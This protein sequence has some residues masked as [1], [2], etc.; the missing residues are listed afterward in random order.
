MGQ[1]QENDRLIT[2][3][4]DPIEKV[5]ED[6]HTSYRGLEDQE[7]E[8]RQLKYGK[9]QLMD[10]RKDTVLLRLRRSF[11]NPFS[12]VLFILAVLSL[13]TNIIYSEKR[14]PDHMSVIIIFS[15]LLL[16]GII[17]FVQE[18]KS[19][20]IT[21]KLND[22]ISSHVW[23]K[24]SGIWQELDMEEIVT[25]DIIKLKAGDKIPADVRLIQSND[26]FVS[27]SVLTGESGIQEKTADVD[28]CIP[29]KISDCGNLAFQGCNV[30][31]GVME[32]VVLA[33]GNHTL[34]GNFSENTMERKKGF[35]RGANS[36]AWVLIRFMAIL[37]PIV[38][39]A[40][41]IT[42]DNWLMAFLFALSVAVGLTPE[43]LPMVVTACL[44]KGSNSMGAKE[45]IVKNMN[46]M[47]GF[48]S[49]DVLCVDKT[50]T[51]TGDELLLE[52]Y[53]DILGNEDQ[54]VLEMAYL[55]SYYSSGIQNHLDQSVIRSIEN[56]KRTE[57]YENLVKKHE[58]LDEIP[59]DYHRKTSSILVK[60]DGKN[61]LIVKGSIEAVLAKCS[62]A[63]Y[64]G[65]RIEK[66]SNAL[67]NVHAIVD[68]MLEDGMKILAIAKK[69]LKKDRIRPDDES[70]LTLAGYIAFFDAPKK[71][72]VTALSTLQN[73][74]VQ[75]KVLTGDDAA[76]AASICRRLNMDTSHVMTGRELENLSDNDSQTA[77][78]YT[79]VFAELSPKQ[80]KEIVSILQS[81]G[82]TVGFMGDGMNDLPAIMQTDVGISVDTASPAVKEAA[83]VILLKKDLNVLEEGILEGRRVF[84]NMSKYIKIT[85]SSNLGNIIA[86]VA[87]SIFLPFFPM[88]SIQLLLLNLLY[89]IICLVLPWDQV[90]RELYEKPLEWSGNRLSRFMLCFG[91]ISSI[92]DIITFGF[93]MFYLCPHL[94]GGNFFVLS[95]LEQ[96]KFIAIFQTGWFLESMWSQVLIL[97]LL[98]TKRFPMVQSRPSNIVIVITLAGI[99]LFT[100]IAMTP[101]GTLIGLTR[102]PAVYFAFLCVTVLCYLIVVTIVKKLYIRFFQNLI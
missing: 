52:Y 44:A 40:S 25:G 57:Y 10:G 82:H 2:A 73:L 85:A 80:K 12:V 74:N 37:V 9:N 6:L 69:D 1:M 39:I 5:Y 97:Y 70:D 96:M 38:F 32:G 8:I 64:K 15:M 61:Q 86:I 20:N 81:N 50:G 18:L 83:D 19:K 49:M 84:V 35:D 3:S 56:L 42:Q 29:E 53:M 63:E 27:Q 4:T 51:L 99:L 72:A 102:L 94:C 71:S 31:S 98:R 78:E 66:D 92:F 13:I 90:D 21:D 47:Q 7:I 62:W 54:N 48:G 76:V 60:A 24:R 91:P 65:E 14:S 11:V 58:K 46:A 88:T 45:T 93:L 79:T 100:V 16:S 59:F 95:H 55:N 22:M 87:A 28:T 30:V 77:I 33:V 67:Q 17:R 75:I 41:G 26:C 34:Y 68:D 89:D 43:L 101:L 23:V 36:I